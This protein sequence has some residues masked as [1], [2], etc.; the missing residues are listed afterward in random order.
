MDQKL[1]QSQ[2]YDLY[3][4]S[5]RTISTCNEYLKSKYQVSQTI[6]GQNLPASMLFRSL[7]GTLDFHL[8]PHR[9]LEGMVLPLQTLS[10]YLLVPE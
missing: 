9:H 5:Y 1:C 3:D 4:V 8:R 7:E 2:S 10:H 6:Q